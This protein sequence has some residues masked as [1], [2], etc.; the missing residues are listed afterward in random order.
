MYCLEFCEKKFDLED[1]FNSGFFESRTKLITHRDDRRV[2][3]KICKILN[4]NLVSNN[5]VNFI[6]NLNR[7]GILD[8]LLPDLE[9]LRQVTQ[10]KKGKVNNAYIHTLKV[11]EQSKSDL[12]QR[13]A[14]LFHDTGK[15]DCYVK[16]HSNNANDLHFYGHEKYSR[17]HAENFFRSFP[18]MLEVKDIIRVL[19]IV[20]F[21]MLPLDYQRNPN[22]SFSAIKRFVDK[23]GKD[24]VFDVIDLAIADKKATNP[25]PEYIKILQ[26]MSVRVKGCID[27]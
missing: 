2:R 7:T 27:G 22:W 13:W 23:V 4:R 9:N 3:E 6:Y 21:H 11:I 20:E 24:Y 14:S 5:A 10:T 8:I 25:N 15:F 12:T 1:T 17:D 26:N 18:E 19:K 16:W